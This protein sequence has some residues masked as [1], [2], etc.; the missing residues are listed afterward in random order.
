LSGCGSA[1]GDAPAR[2]K[3]RDGQKLDR[4]S[5]LEVSSWRSLIVERRRDARA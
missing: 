4:R 2:L 3:A 5:E 1:Y